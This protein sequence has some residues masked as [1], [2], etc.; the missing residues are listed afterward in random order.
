MGNNPWAKLSKGGRV[1]L[2]LLKNFGIDSSN[3]DRAKRLELYMKRV[4]SHAVS[5]KE[6]FGSRVRIVF[7]EDLNKKGNAILKSLGLQQQWDGSLGSN[8]RGESRLFKV[9]AASM[10]R[11]MKTKAMKRSII[12]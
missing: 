12:P 2:N 11:S 4:H 10:K 3:G 1:E 8:A 7:L 9:Q 6:K 5:L